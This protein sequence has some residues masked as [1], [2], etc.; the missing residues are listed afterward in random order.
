[1]HVV[2]TNTWKAENIRELFKSSIC[3]GYL[4]INRIIY[5]RW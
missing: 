4:K 3:N 5:E 2:K 1:M